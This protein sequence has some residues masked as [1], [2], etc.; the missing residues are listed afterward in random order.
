MKQPVR[1]YK[2]FKEHAISYIYRQR[3]NVEI[4]LQMDAKLAKT[5]HYPQGDN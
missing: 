5:S 1:Y 3:R 2:C 4:I